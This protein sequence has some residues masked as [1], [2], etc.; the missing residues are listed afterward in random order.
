MINVRN[1]FKSTDGYIVWKITWIL[2][3]V[4]LNIFE[5]VFKKVVFFGLWM[6][7]LRIWINFAYLCLDG[8]SYGTRRSLSVSLDK[9]FLSKLVL[10]RNTSL[11]FSQR[12]D[13]YPI[14]L[15]L[16][17][18]CLVSYIP[19]RYNSEQDWPTPIIR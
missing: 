13:Y 8:S 1:A 10:K 17:S 5:V 3:T 6:D 15:K 2:L 18:S 14:I 16:I 19:K 4:P 7:V 11:F 9:H 12:L